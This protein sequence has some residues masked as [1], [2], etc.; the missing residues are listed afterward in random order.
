MAKS[1]D[2]IRERINILIYG[3]KE[4]TLKVFR[5]LSLVVSISA[6]G[7]IT[8]YY[9]FPLDKE[10]DRLIFRLIECT[11]GFYIFHY[12]LRLF[13]D[14]HPKQ[15]I[16]SNWLEG[17]IMLILCIEGIAKN[18]FD[19]VLLEQIF[20]SIGFSNFADFSTV[21]VQV[22]L[23]AVALIELFRRTGFSNNRIKL[24]PSTVFIFIFIFLITAGAGLLM[25]PEMTRNPGSMNLLDATFTS[26]S[27]AC[28]TGLVVH[29]TALFFTYKGQF[30]LML[31][32]K[33]GGINIISFAAFTSLFSKLGFGVRHH[34]VIEDFMS[35]DSLLSSKGL[36]G[37]LVLATVTIEAI[38]A[39]FI[40]FTWDPGVPFISLEDKIFHSVFHSI[41]AF[42][43]AGFSTFEAGLFH[44]ALQGSYM[45]HVII[46]VIIFIGGLGVPTV[47]DMFSIQELRKRL[48]YPWKMLSVS[49]KINLYMSITLL[50]IG[51]FAFFM[52]EQKNTLEGQTF[53][54]Q[55]VTS[56][57]SSVTTRTAGF[58]TIDFNSLTLPAVMLVLTL[59]F[60]GAAPAST[61]GG[62]KTSTFFILISSTAAT[63]TGRHTIE[64]SKRTLPNELLNKAL[65]VTLYAA[66][67]IFVSTFV[68]AITESQAL[69][70]G[71]VNFKQL[72]FEVVSAF[73]TVGLSM[74]MT[75][76]LT[77]AG[78]TIIII[79]MF[80]GRIGTL[81][82]AYAFT[83]NLST[84][85]Y[86][87][88][89]ANILV[90]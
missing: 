85:K 77:E 69:S 63:I 32:I 73:S 59:M 87:Y 90:G 53:V 4:D 1:I 51:A 31:L 39:L 3:V 26:A 8:Y 68:L 12:A 45:V 15:F 62:I 70:A 61:G 56:F 41:S 75:P 64:F 89:E 84:L 22:Y 43:N 24:H 58:N 38:G 27:A 72:F 54:E 14:F 33:L 76:N 18:L 88:P 83:K 30:V 82:I 55:L 78:K 36:F 29:D 80:V 16:K 40:F 60:I 86:R 20:V 2:A 52:L 74:G 49:S 25:L 28:V 66:G 10:T 50:L 44:P 5:G 71:I 42:N 37:K 47:L 79:N 46:G 34:E 57:F 67:F 81:T 6:I 13:F 65:S 7:L 11:F 35:K 19:V 9:G 23:L 17:G 21:F 48:E